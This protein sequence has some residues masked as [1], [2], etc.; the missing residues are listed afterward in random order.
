MKERTLKSMTGKRRPTDEEIEAVARAEERN[1]AKLMRLEAGAGAVFAALALLLGA[2]AVGK[3]DVGERIALLV[4]AAVFAALAVLAV[5]SRARTKKEMF[6]FRTGDFLVI[7]GKVRGKMKA[8]EYNGRRVVRFESE[9]G[10]VLEGLREVS[11]QGLSENSPLL[12]ACVSNEDYNKGRDWS[13]T[14]TEADLGIKIDARPSGF[15]GREAG[16]RT[17]D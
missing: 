7:S 10:E 2:G 16:F 15:S 8:S 17:A 1:S 12:L 3:T 13:R 6:F 11:A 4:V 5:R 14:Y 9:K